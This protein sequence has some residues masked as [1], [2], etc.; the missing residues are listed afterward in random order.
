MARR[1]K[2][3]APEASPPRQILAS[4]PGCKTPSSAPLP[5][6]DPAAARAQAHVDPTAV[7]KAASGIALFA[8]VAEKDRQ[9]LWA[10]MFV[11]VYAPGEFIMKQG[12]MG[13]NFYVVTSPDQPSRARPSLPPGGRPAP[14]A[15]ACEHPR[16]PTPPASGAT[17]RGLPTLTRRWWRGNPS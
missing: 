15:A 4:F 6:R 14:L 17:T 1:P 16:P 3:R 10:S 11:C 8:G 2:R 9:I 12:E 7:A 13:L 5:A